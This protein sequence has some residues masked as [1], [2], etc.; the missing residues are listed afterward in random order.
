MKKIN[1][2]TPIT[3]YQWDTDVPRGDFDDILFM[4]HPHI[5]FDKCGIET[6]FHTDKR[7]LRNNTWSNFLKYH[8]ENNLNDFLDD[9]KFKSYVPIDLWFQKTKG[10]V[11]HP[12]HTHGSWDSC[13][14]WSFVWYI[15]VDEKIHKAT[16]Y[17]NQAAEEE[18]IAEMKKGRFILWPSH[19]VH[20]QPAS[21]SNV[22]RCILSGNIELKGRI[23]ND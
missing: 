21:F 9:V 13:T 12:P 1:P 23:A 11:M 18:Y 14:R 16:R 7:S 5:K 22:N 2:F 20:M 4:M 17:Y 8:M 15:D 3:F 10:D 6:D 19:V